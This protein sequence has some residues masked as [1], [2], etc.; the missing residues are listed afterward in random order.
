[1]QDSSSISNQAK[2]IVERAHLHILGNLVYAH[3]GHTQ[4]H[5]EDAML[6]RIVFE[7]KSKDNPDDATPKIIKDIV[8]IIKML[9]EAYN[10]L[11]ID[12]YSWVFNN[13]A[14][15]PI[16]KQSFEL[17]YDTFSPGCINAEYIPSPIETQNFNTFLEVITNDDEQLKKR[18][19]QAIAYIISPDPNPG[20]CVYIRSKSRHVRNLIGKLLRSFFHE[21]IIFGIDLYD[22]GNRFSYFDLNGK[23]LNINMN[24][25]SGILNAKNTR[26]LKEITDPENKF[27]TVRKYHNTYKI[28]NSCKLVFGSEFQLQPNTYDPDFQNRILYLP[29]TDTPDKKILSDA[30]EKNLLSE[31]SSIIRTAMEGYRELR[32][33]GYRFEGQDEYTIDFG[34]NGMLSVSDVLPMFVDECLEPAED[35]FI[36]SYELEDSFKKYCYDLNILIPTTKINLSTKLK[37]Y[38]GNAIKSHKV[39]KGEQTLNGFSGIRFRSSNSQ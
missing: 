27:L 31:K 16:T 26:I 3:D 33:N 9:P 36:F 4:K 29:L 12:N 20:K 5:C 24:I 28:I 22:M 10:K 11:K 23:K 30:F 18:F 7:K 1:M 38:L 25:S 37:K 14:V 34:N 17:S 8:S 32:S 21:D 13:T 19:I 6:N 2:E 39:R 35:G 15:N